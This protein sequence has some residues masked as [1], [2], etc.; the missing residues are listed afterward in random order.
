MAWFLMILCFLRS[1]SQCFVHIARDERLH[2][3]KPSEG[4]VQTLNSHVVVS[5]VGEALC[6]CIKPVQVWPNGKTGY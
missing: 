2:A 5:G 1:I 3:C 4:L 6:V